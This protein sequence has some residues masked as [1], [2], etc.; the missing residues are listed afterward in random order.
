MGSQCKIDSMAAYSS[1]P[2][3]CVLRMF[4]I[5]L[6]IAAR[7][8]DQRISRQSLADECEC[9]VS[10]IK[11]AVNTLRAARIPLDYDPAQR[12]YRLDDMGW[13]LSLAAL[14]G[15][16]ALTLDFA[17]SLLAN[18]QPPGPLACRARSAQTLLRA[19]VPAA[20]RHR[21]EQTDTLLHPAGGLARDYSHAPLDLLWD[22]ARRQQTVQMLYDS[23]NSGRCEQRLADPYRIDQREGRYWEMQAWCHRDRRV[24]TF[25]LD[26]I[27]QARLS[28]QT[29]VVQPWDNSDRGVMGGL[30]DKDWIALEVRFDAV[31]A[32]YAR[33][34]AWPFE[35]QWEEQDDG[36][37]ILRGQVRGAEGVVRELLSW[38]RHAA[39]LGSPELRAHMAE[40]V[41]AMAALYRPDARKRDEK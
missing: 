40:E 36:S 38:R 4:V 6:R 31:V 39:V 11:R 26:R 19:A 20:H 28:G 9:S 24:K 1:D 41:E 29:F 16:Q 21:L 2:V 23:R 13:N 35:A 32:P 17:L 7:R 12:T 5:L 27:E 34:R 37:V 25:A 18:T 33:A 8:P 10:T 15:T 30:R 3:A 14:S 22:A